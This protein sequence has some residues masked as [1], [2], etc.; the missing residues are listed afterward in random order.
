MAVLL[1]AAGL[2]SLLDTAGWRLAAGWS[3]ARVTPGGLLAVGD[4]GAVPGGSV[5]TAQE[6]RDLAVRLFE[7]DGGVAGRGEGRRVARAM[8]DRW[9]HSLAPLSPDEAVAQLL[10]AAPFLWEPPYALARAALAGEMLREAGARLW[11]AGS[12]PFRQ[13]LLARCREAAE[14]RDLLAGPEARTLWNQEEEGDPRELA[15]GGKWRAALAA[16]ERRPPSSERERVERAN[17]F[18]ALGRFEAALEALTGLGSAT[19]RCLAL[20][21]QLQLGALGAARA[22]LLRLGRERLPPEIVVELA[23]IAARV[24]ANRGEGS[25]NVWPWV[26]RALAETSGRGDRA[27]LRARLVA[28]EAA[29]DRKD[30]AAMD[31]WLEKARPALDDPELA[32]RWHHVRGLRMEQDPRGGEEAARSVARAI[33]AG[34]R[35]L[36]RHQAAGLWNDLGLG[37]ARAGDLAGAERAFLHALRLFSGCDGPRRDTLLLPNLAEIRLRRGRLAGVREILERSAAEN[38]L[39][40]NLR[41]ASEDAGLLARHELALGRADAALAL[42]REALAELDRQGSDWHRP[43]LH[44]FAARA[45]GW[46]GRPEEAA[47]DLARSG[48][49]AW[50]ELE[51]E[52][53][54][55]LRAQAGDRAGAL[56]EAEGTP[57]APLW[58]GL[59]AGETPPAP[60][61]EAL[62]NLEPYR[63]ARLVLDLEI[64]SPGTVPAWW[65]REAVSVFRR[66][67]AALL[68]D[69]LDVREERAWRALA[70]YLGR[71]PGDP[72]ALAALLAGAGFPEAALAWHPQDGERQVLVPG[73]GGG[74][75]LSVSL[76][77]GSLVVS[78]GRTDAVLEAVLALS[79]RDLQVP[80]EE[81]GE[82]ILEE[83]PADGIVGESS[84]LRTA[85]ERVARL[86]PG[87]LPVLILGESGTGKELVARRLHRASAR[88]GMPLVTVNCAA[89]TES[90]IVS[91]L[92]GHV[93]GAFTGADR[94]RK[95]LFET[96]HG[97]TIFLDEIGDLPLIAQGMLLRVL[98]EG[99]VRRQGEN[100]TRRVDVRVL[101]ATHRNLARMVSQGTF[102]QDLY[103][104]LKVGTVDLPPLRD[105]GTDVLLLAD[106]FLARRNGKRMR[107]SREARARL[108]AHSWPGNVRELAN[109]LDTAAALADLVIGPEHL[110]LPEMESP[111]AGSYHQQMETFRRQVIERALAACE[112]RQADAARSLGITP[113]ALS[114]F[115]RRL[116]LDQ[117]YG[118]KAGVLSA[119]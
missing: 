59:V 57:F 13:S 19:A 9:R 25:D 83:Q 16:W 35:L 47:A 18:F 96:A 32:W 4:E 31:L 33:R 100:L 5:Q 107:L 101:A 11:V 108:L 84:A 111:R 44:L 66:M 94:D 56:A 49:E 42:C 23:E 7:K 78:A 58:A 29:W 61:W 38:R 88:A 20:R 45:L 71:E 95:G 116:R 102:R 24:L 119:K 63:A 60:A 113:Q 79:A 48:P 93:R 3:S 54:P 82:P 17:A 1:Q 14:L 105:R 27:T 36:P 8:L 43:Q 39:A 106:H 118:A 68:A 26:R 89:L 110:E 86:A 15:A 62:G 28:A 91:E 6:L 92:F 53:R 12:R 40:G 52:E 87:D 112:G 80:G 98:Q 65:R 69:R 117:R 97:G 67:G 73:P 50:K 115:I 37:R 30:L 72:E 85:L 46:L 34:R 109:L 64:A 75:D 114:Y 51:P 76:A 81:T 77:G 70:A 10:E 21:C 90:L 104:R 99:E 2:L 22:A 74:K 103:Y 55:A 41:G